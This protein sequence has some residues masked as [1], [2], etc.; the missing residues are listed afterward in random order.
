MIF[1]ILSVICSALIGNL[2]FLYQKDSKLQIMQV[3][4]G[5][6]FPPR[7]KILHLGWDSISLFLL[8][9]IGV[10]LLYGLRVL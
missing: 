7:K 5:N 8:Y 1:L 9:G 6:Y 3:F 2:L 10:T 4:L